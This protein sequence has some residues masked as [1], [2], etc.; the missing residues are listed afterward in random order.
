MQASGFDARTAISQIVVPIG[1]P[2]SLTAFD[3]VF[4]E[5][6]VAALQSLGFMT[7]PELKEQNLVD[8]VVKPTIYFLPHC[9]HSVTELILRSYLLSHT[10][11]A[12][13]SS[14]NSPSVQ[15]PCIPT[16]PFLLLAN[17]ISS[18]LTAT[19]ASAA[20][21]YTVMRH[22]VHSQTPISRTHAAAATTTPCVQSPILA[23]NTTEEWLTVPQRRGK[24]SERKRITLAPFTQVIASPPELT[25]PPPLPSDTVLPP[26]RLV[27]VPLPA[28]L[29]DAVGGGKA[30]NNMAVMWVHK[31]GALP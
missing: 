22:L 5:N 13:D 27:E 19:T 25:P 24:Q 20:A 12:L 14:E 29:V 4:S 26:A 16:P 30:L 21:P 7:K 11:A 23:T 2:S 9:P 18:F 1:K 10:S 28:W 6:D 15:R 17:S 8:D 3:P 31:E